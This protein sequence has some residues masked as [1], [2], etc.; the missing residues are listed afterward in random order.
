[1]TNVSCFFSEF[2]GT[3]ILVLVLLAVLDSRNGA[4][5]SGLVPLVLFVTFLGINRFPGHGGRC[6]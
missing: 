1:M 6:K 3:A 5:P 4:P 2:L